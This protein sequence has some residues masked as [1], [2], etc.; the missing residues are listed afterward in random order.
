MK[1]IK[2]KI[3]YVEGKPIDGTI[4]DLETIGPIRNE[5]RDTRRY[6]KS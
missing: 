5:F 4:I 6:E 1:Y 2:E 3:L